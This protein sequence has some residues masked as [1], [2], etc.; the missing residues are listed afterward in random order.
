M[1]LRF[2]PSLPITTGMGALLLATL[3]GGCAD[4]ERSPHP[5]A[6]AEATLA[7][8]GNPHT[9]PEIF[10]PGI[11]SDS[12]QQWRI[13]FTPDGKT[14]YFGAS[15]GFFPATRQA[16]I[17]ESHFVDGTWTTPQVAPFSGV[18]SD[19]DPFVSPDGSKLYF[20]SIR[21]VNGVTRLDADTWMVERTGDGGWSEPVN[22]GPAVNSPNDE[23]Y[24]S[25]DAAG[26]LFVASTRPRA[27]GVPRTW[28]IWRSEL[29]NGEYQPAEPLGPGVNSDS[30][31]EFN[32]T[33]TP[34]GKTLLFGTL[35]RADL[36][37]M[38]DIYVSHLH[39][40]E[41]TRARNLGAPVNTDVDEY[42][43]SLSPDGKYLYFLRNSYE[44]GTSGNIYRIRTSALGDRLQPG[45]TIRP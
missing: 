7:L 24:P 11:I 37:G 12:R 14:A 42:H 31:W 22:L 30:S 6:A 23:L 44:A 40:G 29:V 28:N 2:P 19:I 9:E 34:D 39:K 43:P 27:P 33:V 36:L 26:N 17:Y 35:F 18:Y 38:G 3:T 1:R 8:G 45:Y 4:S 25:V 41:W 15:D 10:A 21:P 13:T 5:L 16:W 20:S 32:P